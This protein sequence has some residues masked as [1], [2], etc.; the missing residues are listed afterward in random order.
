MKRSEMVK[1]IKNKL[2]DSLGVDYVSTKTAEDVLNLIEE[3][4]MKPPKRYYDGEDLPIN[5]LTLPMSSRTW[6]PK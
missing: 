5:F 4:G 3:A 2:E 1:A 6:K